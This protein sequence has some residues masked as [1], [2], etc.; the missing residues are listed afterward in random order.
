M[1]T[2]VNCG[3]YEQGKLAILWLMRL[4]SIRKY[5]TWFGT[6]LQKFTTGFD[7]IEGKMTMYVHLKQQVNTL[8][9]LE[10]KHRKMK[11]IQYLYTKTYK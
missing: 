5:Y 4:S 3:Y 8:N 9:R 2:I 11:N 1:V 6:H 10:N 7:Q